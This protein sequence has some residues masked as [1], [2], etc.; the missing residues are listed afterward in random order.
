METHPW[1]IF[2][3]DSRERL[4]FR[5]W[6]LLGEAI[7]KFEHLAGAPIQ[8]VLADRLNEIY[9][10]KS[11]H[12]TTRIE[13][14]TLTADE[15]LQRVRHEL[16]LPPSQEYLG[17]EVDNIVAAYNLIEFDLAE[18]HSLALTRER[19]D[20][21][22]RLVLDKVPAEDDVH[23]GKVRTKNVLVGNYRG[24]P[25]QDC[26]HLL[27]RLC[28]WLEM[29]R[30]EAGEELRQPV[31][32]ISALLAHLYLAWIHPFGDG[33]GRTARLVE[34]QLLLNAR[35]PMLA[36]H[37]PANFYMRTRTRYYQVLQKTSQPPYD[38]AVFLRYAIQG[39]VE[40]L[41]E[42]VRT[43]QGHQLGVAWVNYVHET[44]QDGHTAACVR[45]RHLVLDLPM[46]EFTPISK[47]P[48]LTPRLAA[49]YASKT[50]RT[51]S[52]DVNALT[53]AGLL[54]R[55]RAGVRPHIEQMQ[56]F[57]PLRADLEHT[58]A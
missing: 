30:A 15:V 26:D 43:I 24:A 49:E 5:T 55:T 9:L 3:F 14:N 36:A 6:M 29:M 31:A 18:G 13:G 54:L 33:N 48:E 47:I 32:I 35:A 10:S 37:L 25:P 2:D 16:E 7:S 52:R 21:L 34:Y 53:D 17:Q 51:V 46:H 58:D 39:F 57:L 40:E 23:P 8:P 28:D 38:P 11:V 4:D 44:V 1:L 27:D 12:A 42:Q 20:E 41:R 56:A 22:N 45:Q 19:V 50:R